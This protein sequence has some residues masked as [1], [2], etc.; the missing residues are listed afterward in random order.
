MGGRASRLEYTHKVKVALSTGSWMLALEISSIIIL[1][2]NPSVSQWGRWLCAPP[3]VAPLGGLSVYSYTKPHTHLL[4]CQHQWCIDVE[5][6]KQHLSSEYSCMCTGTCTHV[7]Y[8]SA[9][10]HPCL[11]ATSTTCELLSIVILKR[12]FHSCSIPAALYMCSS[13]K[14][15]YLFSISAFSF[16]LL[17][18]NIISL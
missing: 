5:W 4:H 14:K 10:W 8:I 15:K 13:H 18:A 1:S 16:E 11:V 6:T 2:L 7:L 12:A 9:P 17:L 3:P